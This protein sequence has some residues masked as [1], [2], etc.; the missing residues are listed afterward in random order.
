MD[1]WLLR[2][3]ASAKHLNCAVQEFKN[4]PTFNKNDQLAY[5][6]IVEDNDS[7][8]RKVLCVEIISPR[9]MFKAFKAKACLHPATSKPV[10]SRLAM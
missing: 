6:M 3:V 8:F 10:S 5:L 9:N 1:F 4:E 2:R 7:E